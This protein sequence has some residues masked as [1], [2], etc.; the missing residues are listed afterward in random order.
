ML[1]KKQRQ[2]ITEVRK[3]VQ[4][5]IALVKENRSLTISREEHLLKVINYLAYWLADETLVDAQILIERAD[6]YAKS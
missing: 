4:L 3:D 6:K 5:A 1:S 2:E